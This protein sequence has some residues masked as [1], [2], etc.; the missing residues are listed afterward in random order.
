MK[1]KLKNLLQTLR[2]L[3]R[4]WNDEAA[5]ICPATADQY[6]HEYDARIETP[7]R[8]TTSARD[9]LAADPLE[10]GRLDGDLPR[11]TGDCPARPEQWNREM[12]AAMPL[13]V[14][15]CNEWLDRTGHLH[16][17]GVPEPDVVAAREI[18]IAVESL[19]AWTLAIT[20][21]GLDQAHAAACRAA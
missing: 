11:I 18:G 7:H 21:H 3:W 19:R 17:E 12:L 13:T 9:P 8:R 2:A 10:C 15:C 6:D 20:R 4:D 5:D 1:T 16:E 14:A